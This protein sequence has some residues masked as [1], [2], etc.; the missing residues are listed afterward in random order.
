[1]KAKTVKASSE[2][3]AAAAEEGI[4]DAGGDTDA[5]VAADAEAGEAESGS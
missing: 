3:A 1:M 5:E 2:E 4:T